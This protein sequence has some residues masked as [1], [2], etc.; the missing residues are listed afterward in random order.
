MWVASLFRCE[1]YFLPWSWQGIPS[2]L[3]Y[4][5]K[6]GFVFSSQFSDIRMVVV[7]WRGELLRYYQGDTLRELMC[8]QINSLGIIKSALSRSLSTKN[9]FESFEPNNQI[10][11]QPPMKWSSHSYDDVMLRSLPINGIK[12]P[13]CSSMEPALTCFGDEMSMW[14][15]VG[16]WT[17][18]QMGT[19]AWMCCKS[20]THGI[21]PVEWTITH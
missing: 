5:F 1:L 13:P 16:P 9:D 4:H 17:K 19:R 6:E 2:L 10:T 15:P 11:F 14:I 7:V 12:T 18:L 20:F 3:S 8:E 21:S